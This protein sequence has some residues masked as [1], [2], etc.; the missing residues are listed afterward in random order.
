M[1]AAT[2]WAT[3]MRAPGRAEQTIIGLA[4]PDR[5]PLLPVADALWESAA[6]LAEPFS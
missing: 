1:V 4:V 2:P 6:R 5:E 3:S